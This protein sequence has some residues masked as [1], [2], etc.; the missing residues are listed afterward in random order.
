MSDRWQPIILKDTVVIYLRIFASLGLDGLPVF[1]GVDEPKTKLYIHPYPKKRWILFIKCHPLLFSA[2]NVVFRRWREYVFARC[3][4][5]KKWDLEIN[6]LPH[7]FTPSPRKETIQTIFHGLNKSE[8]CLKMFCCSVSY[9]AWSVFVQRLIYNKP[10]S[11]P[12][13]I[14][15]THKCVTEP[16]WVNSL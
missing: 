3:G 15:F 5:P 4:N 11:K 16:W 2:Q 7:N 8:L 6:S 14:H 12:G 13:M 10:W 1:F 9:D